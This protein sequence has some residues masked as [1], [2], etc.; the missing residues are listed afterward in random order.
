MCCTC[1][2]NVLLIINIIGTA[3]YSTRLQWGAS[4]LTNFTQLQ[5]YYRYWKVLNLGTVGSLGG[6]AAYTTDT[7]FSES[8]A[9]LDALRGITSFTQLQ[10]IYSTTTNLLQ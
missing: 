6:C 7:A 3:S 4:Y 10:Q 2:A 5:I 8:D 1:G 9:A